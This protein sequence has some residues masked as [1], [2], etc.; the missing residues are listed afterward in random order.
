MFANITISGITLGIYY[1]FLK[2]KML[3]K[4]QMSLATAKMQKKEHNSKQSLLSLQ[5]QAFVVAVI[6]HIIQPPGRLETKNLYQD[7]FLIF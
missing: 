6:F 3:S 2:Q 1:T 7:N 5:V 4:S